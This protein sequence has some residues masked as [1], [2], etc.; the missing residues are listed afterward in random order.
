MSIKIE[1]GK[2]YKNRVGEIIGPIEVGESYSYPFKCNGRTY[3]KSGSVYDVI[4][5]NQDL[6]EEIPDTPPH[7]RFIFGAVV[8]GR[9]PVPVPFKCDHRKEGNFYKRDGK[10]ICPTSKEQIELDFNFNPVTGVT[11]TIKPVNKRVE[12]WVTVKDGQTTGVYTIEP[13]INIGGV[14]ILHI[15]LDYEED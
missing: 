6:T 3:T 13:S 7:S 4:S 10:W 15:V 1:A 8:P 12:F 2:R 11:H 14:E 9:E 5:C